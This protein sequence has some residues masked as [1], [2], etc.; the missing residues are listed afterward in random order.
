MDRDMGASQATGLAGAEAPEPSGLG[1][2]D[3]IPSAARDLYD[4][5]R[6]C[7]NI[8]RQLREKA[9]AAGA[10]GRDAKQARGASPPERR[11]AHRPNGASHPQ[12]GNSN[13]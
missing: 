2:S 9:I 13:G 7:I 8:A 6:R 5:A 11:E 4:L 12:E 3:G 10:E 1:P